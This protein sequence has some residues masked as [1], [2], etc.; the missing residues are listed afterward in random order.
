MK[1]IIIIISIYIFYTINAFSENL[2][3]TMLYAVLDGSCCGGEESDPHAVHG[4]EVLNNGFILSGKSIDHKGSEEGF[5]IKLPQNMP[6]E[7]LYLH[8]EE[9]YNFDWSFTFGSPGRRDGANGAASIYESV[10]VAGYSE[11]RNK[12]IDGYL[13]KINLFDGNL[14]WS[15]T[16]SSKNKNK[17]TAFE[18]ILITNDQGLILSGVT[19]SHKDSFEGFKSYGNPQSGETVVMYFD[20]ESLISNNPPTK[21]TWEIVLQNS[22]SGIAIKEIIKENSFVIATKTNNEEGIAKIIK[23]NNH[24][25]IIWSKKYP[26]FGEITDIDVSSLDGKENG[27]LISGHKHDNFD[28]IDGSI[29]KVSLDGT[30]IWNY[31]FGNPIGGKNKFSKIKNKNEKMVLDECWGISAISDGGAVMAC[32]TGI[33]ECEMFENDSKLYEQCSND[34][35]TTWRSLL[36]R[37]DKDGKKL[38]QHVDSFVFPG[39]EDEFDVPSTASEYV[40]ITSDNRTASVVDL[41]FGIGLQILEQ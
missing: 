18:S 20:K 31:S 24:G 5:V 35:R 36:I 10:F 1:K 3:K 26:N 27:I 28:G 19:N 41:G 12:V 34:P 37:V 17:N 16:F 22:R 15:K 39:E 23:I 25:K 14:E 8:E 13:A 9:E 7:R 11:N 21:P 32:G 30:L 33:E 4:I 40:F 2:P 6:N 38:W 29:G